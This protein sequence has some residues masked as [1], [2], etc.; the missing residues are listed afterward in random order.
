VEKTSPFHKNRANG[1]HADRPA[2]FF[3]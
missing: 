3:Y 1:L 2:V